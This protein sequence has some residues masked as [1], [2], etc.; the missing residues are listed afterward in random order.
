MSTNGRVA[1]AGRRSGMT[2]GGFTGAGDST[3]ETSRR[4]DDAPPRK[5][6]GWGSPGDGDAGQ[7]FAPKAGRRAGRGRSSNAGGAGMGGGGGGGGGGGWTTS[8]SEPVAHQER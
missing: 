7:A 3:A 2:Q 1:K 8:S 5:A 6:T 4:G